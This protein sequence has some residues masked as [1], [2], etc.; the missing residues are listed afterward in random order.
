MSKIIFPLFIAALLIFHCLCTPADAYSVLS[1]NT[2]EEG[3][4]EPTTKFTTSSKAVYINIVTLSAPSDEGILIKLDWYRPD[5]TREDIDRNIFIPVY[6]SGTYVGFYSYMAIKGDDR[7]LGEW[8]VEHWARGYSGGVL[9]WY[10]MC[11]T[12]FNITESVANPTFSPPQGRYTSP[13]NV[14]LSCSTSSAV[15]HYSTDGSEPT[16]SSPIYFTPI[17]V[18]ETTTINAKTYKNGLTPSDT[19]TGTYTISKPM[20]WIPLLLLD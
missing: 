2:S 7:Q 18:S 16:N 11:A 5:G 10:L 8:R 3:W 20:P 13:Q 1:C 17:N 4:G 12:S 19:V 14:T 9:D 6:R 15:I